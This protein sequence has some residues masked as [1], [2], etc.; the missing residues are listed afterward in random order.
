M[1]MTSRRVKRG[2]R[3]KKYL[4]HGSR[5]T[6]RRRYTKIQRIQRGGKMHKVCEP[7]GFGFFKSGIT[8]TYDDETQMYTIGSKPY[9]QL[10]D[11]YGK[12]KKMFPQG[13][14]MNGDGYINLNQTQFNEFA[15]QY[16]KDGSTDKQ[17]KIINEFRL[18]PPASAAA[19]SGDSETEKIAS[20]D[21]TIPNQLKINETHIA[22]MNHAGIVKGFKVDKSKTEYNFDNFT[23]PLGDRSVIAGN[24]NVQFVF[25]V[26]T[27]QVTTNFTL[28][29]NVDAS[30][31]IDCMRQL[32]D[33]SFV[34]ANITSIES[35][36]AFSKKLKV[37]G[38]VTEN[39]VFHKNLS[40][41]DFSYLIREFAKQY[42]SC[43]DP[44][45]QMADLR[46]SGPQ[47]VA[48]MIKS[49]IA[50]L[51]QRSMLPDEKKIFEALKQQ[52]VSSDNL[53]LLNKKLDEFADARRARLYPAAGGKTIRKNRNRR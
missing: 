35:V 17:C 32:I 10:S 30:N 24:L 27:R 38:D 37:N 39:R 3:S 46:I 9:A 6:S 40:M 13:L 31:L 53:E 5:K 45:Q 4:H 7:T 20:L 52:F 50:M 8:I 11:D 1:G 47:D 21:A 19:T 51:E 16:C 33:K 29:L 36:G 28:I 34:G 41:Y 14:P 22:Y 12:L 44:A 49:K 26:D 43:S 42:Q 15:K 18:A 25:N 23:I 48:R 2:K